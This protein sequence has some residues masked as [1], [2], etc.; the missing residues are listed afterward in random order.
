ESQNNGDV[1][2][3]IQIYLPYTA[4]QMRFLGRT[5]VRSI[6]L[7]IADNVDSQLAETMI[8][9]LLIMRHGQED[10]FIRNSEVF[11][12]KIMNSTEIL[13]LLVTSIAAI[14][15]VVGGIGVMNIMLVTVSERINEIGVRMAIG[16][17][18]SDILQQFLIESILVCLIGGSLG[19]LFGLAIGGLFMLGNSPIQLIYTVRSIIIAVLFAAFIGV[20]FGFFPARKA[21]QLDPVAALARD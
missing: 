20:G 14:S 16:A 8:R 19:V 9:R 6:V 4:V 15:L 3:T 13:T 1:S 5:D 11:R 18:Q 17:R 2:D 7:K 21:S 12:K 10:F